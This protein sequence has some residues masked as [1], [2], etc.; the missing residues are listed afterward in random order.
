LRPIVWAAC[1][2]GLAACATRG[3]EP[4]PPPTAAV[5]QPSFVQTGVASW[6]GAAHQGHQT[7]SGERFDQAVMTAAHMTLPLGTFVRV[8]SL[9]TGKSIKVRINDRGP[10]ARGRIID[11][12]AEAAASLDLRQDGGG[13]VKLEVFASDQ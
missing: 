6:Y 12:S 4:P 1:V 8:T 10:H 3:P 9:N 13:P 5:E 7:T 11:L 2:V